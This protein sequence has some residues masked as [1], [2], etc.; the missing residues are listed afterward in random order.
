M[1]TYN[2]ERFIAQAIESVLM[3]ETAFP[4]E[5]VIGEDCSTDGTRE[6][7]RRYAG[8]RADI[9]RPLLHERNLGMHANFDTVLKACRGDYLAILEGDDYWTGVQKLQM[10]ADFLDEH[11]KFSMCF[12][13]VRFV[14]DGQQDA[15]FEEPP[16]ERRCHREL[17]SLLRDNSIATCSV[18]VRR[19]CLPEPALDFSSLRIGD[20]P[21][22]ILAARQ[23]PAGYLDET[24]GDHRFHGGG[25]WT[26]MRGEQRCLAEAD[27]FDWIQ[28]RIPARFRI[29]ARQSSRQR[30]KEARMMKHLCHVREAQAGASRGH[31]LF[32]LA[33]CAAAMPAILLWRPFL[34]E[35]AAIVLGPRLKMV[36]KRGL[37]RASGAR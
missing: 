25:V 4:I 9:V 23:G 5:L 34:S 14:I 11:P 10:Q 18:M 20:Y 26:A 35:A 13:R 27:M 17:E 15:F 21:M 32:A 19:S 33:N 7:V 6:I 37:A 22:W 31:Q 24:M 12:H 3:Q 16:P 8:S 36:I 30:R 1:I 2:H 29:I 28:P